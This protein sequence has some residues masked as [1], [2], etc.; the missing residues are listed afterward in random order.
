[1]V[2]LPWLR[3]LSPT[4]HEFEF[5]WPRLVTRVSFILIDV[6][7][8]KCCSKFRSHTQIGSAAGAAFRRFGWATLGSREEELR[9]AAIRSGEARA[10]SAP[11]GGAGNFRFA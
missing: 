9:P 10:S 11:E 1:M 2:P 8:Q 5:Y 4:L 6:G 3:Q 7:Y